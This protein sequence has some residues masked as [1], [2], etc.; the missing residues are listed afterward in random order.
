MTNAQAILCYAN[1][2]K[3]IQMIEDDMSIHDVAEAIKKQASYY[4]S[5]VKDEASFMLAV[6]NAVQEA[7]RKFR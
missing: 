3:M 6:E 4:G 7:F 5:F 2:I 1:P